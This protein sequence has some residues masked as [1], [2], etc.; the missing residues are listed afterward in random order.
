M[1]RRPA[2]V[3]AV[4]AASALVLLGALGWITSLTLALERSEVQA[5]GKAI[6]EE[7]VRIAL[8]RMDASLAELVARENRRSAA[9][10][11]AAALA[12]PEPGQMVR[13]RFE[14]GPAREPVRGPGLGDAAW[15]AALPLPPPPP[16]SVRPE[17]GEAAL[18]RLAHRIEPPPVPSEPAKV[19]DATDPWEQLIATPGVLVDR[20]N[21]GA[22]EAGQQTAYSQEVLNAQAF[23]RRQE[24]AQQ[25]I[26]L[27]L[28]DEATA[29]REDAAEAPALEP[30]E[31]L[32]ATPQPESSVQDDAVAETGQAA[33][34]KDVA[35]STPALPAAATRAP[36][37]AHRV[38]P[39]PAPPAEVE[40]AFEGRWVGDELLLLR[41]VLD[42]DER[43][44]QGVRLDWPA[45]SQGLLAQVAEVV[46]GSRL[47]PS[48]DPPDPSRQLAVLPLRL[49]PGPPRE[50]EPPDWTPV[51]LTLAAA[52]GAA[53]LCLAGVG[54]L[55]AGSMTLA[56]RRADFV[57]AV[58]HELRTPLT[59]LRLYSDLLVEDAVP[60]VERGSY[61]ATLKREADRLGHLVDNVLSFSR[62]ERVRAPAAREHAT[63]RELLARVVPRLEE[64]V[65]LAGLKLEVQVPEELAAERVRLDLASVE[66]ILFNLVDNAC[67]YGGNAERPAL[68]LAAEVRGRHAVLTL[69]DQGQGIGERERRRLFRPFH[70]SAAQAAGSAPGV[71][72]GLALSR[73]LAR[74]MGGDLR[75]AKSE[76]GASFELR[77]RRA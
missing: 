32:A 19:A 64:R 56:Q 49:V 57:S 27:S 75:L 63:L 44:L 20:L 9:Q 43:L 72:L 65:A 68:R 6:A 17:F 36:P 71:G 77:L 26:V 24:L 28:P 12:P 35:A 67:K 61:I 30:A 2:V 74:R 69:A 5:L 34:T 38:S 45:L 66:Q 48:S 42:G 15:I 4:F 47:E 76:R 52:W 54:A 14:L 29:P 39:R 53:L 62:L 23:Q 21:V 70:R 51:R 60:P 33:D 8:W 1:I 41:Q 7:N 37:R 13:A 3:A 18:P 16:R 10:H 11:R 25:N 50:A 73:R 22:N 31:S 58:T 59:T 40:S 55:L 46:P